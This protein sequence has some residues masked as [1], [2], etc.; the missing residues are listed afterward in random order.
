MVLVVALILSMYL[1]LMVVAAIGL[2]KASAPVVVPV[3]A[4]L[5]LSVII[6]FR[7][8]SEAM[9]L[10][11]RGLAGLDYPVSSREFIFVDDHS[12]DDSAEII[13]AA[14]LHGCNLLSLPKG[15]EG[16]KH[17]LT[18]GAQAATGEVLVFTDADCM[19]EAAWL[20]SVS[21]S[22]TDN[23][24]NMA[25]G[26]VRML[27]Y[28]L[29]SLEF[30]SLTAITA[31]AT[32]LGHPLMCNG[33]NL[34]C[35]RET[36]FQVGG[37]EGNFHVQ[38]GDDEFLMRKIHKRFPGTIRLMNEDASVV[39]T[40][41]QPD[42]KAFIRQR[43]RWAGKWKFNTDSV[44]RCTAVFVFLVQVATIVAAV[45]ILT[46][47]PSFLALLLGLKILSEGL[48]LHRI[49]LRIGIPFRFSVFASASAIYPFYVMA[50][51]SLSFFPGNTWKGRNERVR[52]TS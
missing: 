14:G 29:Q 13:S 26:L 28:G 8:E 36:F 45:Q 30:S 16:K 48:L 21:W 4:P 39:T 3:R 20:S 33:A 27:P 31:A 1:L 17:A 24:T 19:H 52:A 15:V 35:R 43:I 49:A 44:A 38:S 12:T 2:N 32:A 42:L 5:K 40:G 25:I 41:I 37:Y 10:L 9:P 34:A 22:F 18:L 7:N 11:L 50:V 46:S 51:G 6:P 23:K 47:P